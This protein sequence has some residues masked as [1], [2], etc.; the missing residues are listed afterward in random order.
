MKPVLSTI[1][2][3]SELVVYRSAYGH[4]CCV[5]GKMTCKDMLFCIPLKS[6]INFLG[7]S[8]IGKADYDVWE[9]QG[10]EFITPRR[11]LGIF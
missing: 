8:W 5:P 6:K 10:K 2:T 1:K 7:I 4:E 11:A 3:T 9:Y